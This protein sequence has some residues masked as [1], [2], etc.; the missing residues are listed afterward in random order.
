MVIEKQCSHSDIRRTIGGIRC[1]GCYVTFPASPAVGI[2][3]GHIDRINERLQSQ[4]SNIT[5]ALCSLLNVEPCQYCGKYIRNNS[6][7]GTSIAG[8]YICSDCIPRWYEESAD[9]DDQSMLDSS[10]DELYAW[11]IKYNGTV[12]KKF[13][14]VKS[15]DPKGFQKIYNQIAR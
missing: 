11:I 15:H 7:D 5:N 4:V 2:L 10:M 6:A 12:G 1:A 14:W 9:Y 8:A 3:L 13:Q